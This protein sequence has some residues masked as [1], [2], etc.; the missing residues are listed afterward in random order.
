MVEFDL[1]VG[2]FGDPLLDP[3]T[4]ASICE[5][6]IDRQNKEVVLAVA[7]PRFPS[8]KEELKMLWMRKHG[9]VA[10]AL[11]PNYAYP[12]FVEAISASTSPPSNYSP[13]KDIVVSIDQQL[14]R[15]SI[16]WFARA[17]C[18]LLDSDGLP[19]QQQRNFKLK[20]KNYQG[21]EFSESILQ[22]LKRPRIVSQITSEPVSPGDGAIPLQP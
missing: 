17:L 13:S 9:S 3:S 7:D 16:A 22:F 14:S 10:D 18:Q 15:E 6:L 8:S 5:C 11:N 20:W 4:T 12:P 1:T 2:K 19:E 21:E